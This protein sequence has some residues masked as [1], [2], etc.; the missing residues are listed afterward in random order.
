MI[1]KHIYIPLFFGLLLLVLACTPNSTTLKP[2]E[3]SLPAAPSVPE[4]RQPW[5]E[6]WLKTLAAAKKERSVLIY[7]SHGYSLRGDMTKILKEKYGINLEVLA[8]KSAQLTEKFLSEQRNGLHL[9]DVMIS[10]STSILTQLKPTKALAPLEPALMLP[11]VKGPENWL[12]GQLDW[13]DRERL[14]LSFEASMSG[15]LGINTNLVNAEEIKSLKDLLNPKWKGKIIVNDPSIAGTGAKFFGVIV[16]QQGLDIWREI[17]RMEPLV[18]RDERL[19]TDWLTHGKYAVII[20]PK[21]GPFFEAAQAGAPIKFIRVKEGNYRTGDVISWMRDSPHPNAAKVFLNW[22]LSREGQTLYHSAEG[23][24]SGR[25][26]V[27]VEGDPA[28]RPEPGVAYF[29]GNSE[30][31]LLRQPDHMETAKQIFAPFMR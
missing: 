1:G 25:A 22:F 4:N 10:G 24:W 17:A 28:T 8:G 14:I 27:T 15:K 18:L 12:G 3:P 29:N 11:D 20:S 23:T 9:A 7:T 6:D 13:V 30:E 21:T 5:E 2:K 26:D 19:M 16:E 31:F